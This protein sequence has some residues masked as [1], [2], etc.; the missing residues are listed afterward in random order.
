MFFVVLVSTIVQGTTLEWVAGVLGLVAPAPPVPEAPLE[1]GPM[2]QLDLV[3][4][5]VAATTPS[6][7][8]SCGRSACRGTR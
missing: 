2:S 5:A 8:P 7:V 6:A 4:F 1:V 3:E